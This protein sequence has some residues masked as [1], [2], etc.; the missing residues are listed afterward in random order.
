MDLVCDHM[1]PD[2]LSVTA[3]EALARCARRMD[4]HAR[5]HLPVV[6]QGGQ[7][8]GMLHDLDVAARL[9]EPHLTAAD[10]VAPTVAVH[11]AD[12]VETA[13]EAV[14]GRWAVPVIRNGVVVGVFTEEDA[15]RVLTERLG[16]PPGAEPVRARPPATTSPHEPA[17][18]A[19]ER[20]LR[21]RFRHLV[22]VDATGR[23]TGVLALSDLWRADV[24]SAPRPLTVGDVGGQ[25][26]LVAV[27]EPAR[28]REVA[29][30][31]ATSTVGCLPVLDA[32]GRPI[33]VVTRA[34]LVRSAIGVDREAGTA[35]AA[36]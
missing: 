30:L 12:D 10:V 8:L 36:R 4:L 7:L 13:L 31:L 17:V 34:D 32:D 27:H 6:G 35:I 25:R 28:M 14:V 1:T 3:D 18:G 16:G 29:E 15:V 19:L 11:V 22:I 33:R 9:R 21:G 5:W 2:P 20:L 24:V 23:A 26:P